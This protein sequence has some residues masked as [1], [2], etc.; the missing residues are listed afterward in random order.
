[1]SVL[2][3][4]TKYFTNEGCGV[5]LVGCESHVGGSG[6]GFTQKKLQSLDVMLSI[7]KYIYV[8]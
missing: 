6:E 2:L 1:M 7:R 5:G 4:Q 3:G 8:M